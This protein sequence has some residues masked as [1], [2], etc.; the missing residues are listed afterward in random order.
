M[1]KQAKEINSLKTAAKVDEPVEMQK[2]TEADSTLATNDSSQFRKQMEEINPVVMTASKVDELEM[3]M[4]TQTDST[5]DGSP[6][7]SKHETDDEVRKKAYEIS[8][9]V[10]PT[11][12]EEN[13][14]HN[15]KGDSFH[16]KSNHLQGMIDRLVRNRENISEGEMELRSFYQMDRQEQSQIGVLADFVSVAES[17]RM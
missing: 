4:N 10:T 16:T 12:K 1:G 2:N 15:G 5:S 3:R 8:P 9:L 13:I 17:E 14:L 6:V 11:M 7:A